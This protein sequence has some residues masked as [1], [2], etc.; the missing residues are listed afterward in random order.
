MKIVY[1]WTDKIFGETTYDK[2]FN[3]S[4]DY[5]V[6]FEFNQCKLEINKNPKCPPNFYGRNISDIIAIVGE[7]GVGKTTIIKELASRSYEMLYETRRSNQFIEIYEEN[8]ELIIYYFFNEKN[9]I[10]S[11]DNINKINKIDIGKTEK[12]VINLGISSAYISNS[13]DSLGRTTT[14]SLGILKN[15]TYAPAAIL[16]DISQSAKNEYGQ[17]YG[18]LIFK[19]IQYYAEKMNRSI[20]N[21]YENYEAKNFIRTYLKAPQNIISNFVGFKY[22]ELGVLQFGYA[23][24]ISD[25]G[26]NYITTLK[27]FVVKHN[28]YFKING[29]TDLFDE[30][31]LNIIAEAIIFFG[32]DKNDKLN[33]LGRYLIKIFLKAMDMD[34]L[35]VAILEI[36]PKILLNLIRDN[37]VK[38][39][40]EYDILTLQYIKNNLAQK[41]ENLD[42]RW[43]KDLC[44]AILE[45]KYV[46]R[47]GIEFNIGKVQKKFKLKNEEKFMLFYKSILDKKHSIFKRYIIFKRLPGST[48]ERAFLNL[49]GYIDEFLSDSI[50]KDVII[51]IDEIDLYLHPRW[52]QLIL[53]YLINWLE[54]VYSDRS[55]QLVITTHSPILLSDF[56]KERVIRLKKNIESELNKETLV[57]SPNLIF[58]ANIQTLFYDNFFMDKG[59]IAELAKDKIKEA[60]EIIEST[61]TLNESDIK[62]V[63]YIIKNIGDITVRKILQNKLNRKI[64]IGLNNSIEKNSL[65]LQEKIDKIGISNALKI[66]EEYEND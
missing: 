10:I 14:E 24:N 6:K 15:K 57:E 44:E 19:N 42:I 35:D 12:K 13:F 40:I 43:Y 16:S 25:D 2:G 56:T 48:G 30:C 33:L 45:Y 50:E 32:I 20:F 51:F 5:Q 39:K 38:Y 18:N 37:I 31:Y 4:C 49:I 27:Q 58:G 66:L 47:A 41:E 3:L 63:K 61:K 34:F 26:L 17:A 23:F 54:E 53:K 22:A 7:N 1:F 65:R 62:Y 64:E 52:Q 11:H 55:I 29:G 8:S 9:L 28:D 46:D 60:L 36:T 59:S 21:N